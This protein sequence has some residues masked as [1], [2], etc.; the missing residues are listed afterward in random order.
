MTYLLK[1]KCGHKPKRYPRD[2]P[3]AEKDEL[4][5]VICTNCDLSTLSWYTQGNADF[6]W[7]E[8]IKNNNNK[9]ELT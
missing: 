5:S 2:F 3:D 1:C 7:N 4:K 6:N 9:K 8:L